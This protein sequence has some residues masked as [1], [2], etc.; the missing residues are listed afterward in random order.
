MK[1]FIIFKNLDNKYITLPEY[2][3]ANKEKANDKVYYVTD[4]QQQSQYVN[5]FKAEGIDALVLSH[6]IDQPFISQLEQQD[7]KIHFQRIDADI[8]DS[9]KEEVKEGEEADKIKE[10]TDALTELFRK[11]LNND[12]LEVKVEKLKNEEVSSMVTLSEESRRMQDMMRMY[13]MAGMDP[14]MF[15]TSVTLVLNANNKLVQYIFE[16]K[17]DDV[18]IFCEQL[19]DLA[20]LSQR[21]LDPEAMTK[22][23]SRS[24]EIMLKM[25]K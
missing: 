5:M 11:V 1:D 14:S 7:D 2:V 17:D 6:N 3:E 12:K 23:I 4:L 20:L 24:N 22:F 13:N 21:P 18:S 19:Y 8:T 9:F 15:G 25:A 10:E 16:H